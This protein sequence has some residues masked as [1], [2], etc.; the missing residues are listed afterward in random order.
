MIIY[1]I[2]EKELGFHMYQGEAKETD[3]MWTLQSP[4]AGRKKIFKSDPLA[5][6]D[7][8]ELLVKYRDFIEEAINELEL[9]ISK[10][11]KK[12]QTV[13]RLLEQLEEEY[14]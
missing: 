11:D 7:K 9:K 10:E 13:E 6:S 2:Q 14:V 3:N 1:F 12:L 4:I 8:R 5:S